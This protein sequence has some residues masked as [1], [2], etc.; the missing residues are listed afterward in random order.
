MS[1]AG[2]AEA[3][4]DRPLI[5]VDR[6]PDEEAKNKRVG[7]ENE[8]KDGEREAVKVWDMGVEKTDPEEDSTEIEGGIRRESS[9][10]E[11]NLK[12]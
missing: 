8:H 5:R 3:P 9:A 2:A 11:T 10:S 12:V 6:V 1:I 7:S 4:S